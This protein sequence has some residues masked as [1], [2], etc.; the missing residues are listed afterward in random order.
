[1]MRPSG[2]GHGPLPCGGSDALVAAVLTLL[3]FWLAFTRHTSG[4]LA[5]WLFVGVVAT[6]ATGL[7][8]AQVRIAGNAREQSLNEY[9]LAPLAGGQGCAGS[10]AR[11]RADPLRL[12]RA[13][14]PSAPH[15]ASR[16]RYFCTLP[17]T[18]I[19][20]ASTKRT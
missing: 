3:A 1:M 6:I 13:D 11:H 8:F 5:W 18:V 7:A 4:P 10:G 15:I 14:S 2:R 16:I 9:E 20:N 19:G 12:P 17:V